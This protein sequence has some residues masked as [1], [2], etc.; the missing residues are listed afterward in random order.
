MNKYL[1]GSCLLVLS[2]SGCS[3]FSTKKD[4]VNTQSKEPMTTPQSDLKST[5]IKE[6]PAD[7]KKPTKGST[8]VV[9]YTGWLSDDK[10]QPGKKF[11]S[12][13]DRG[14]PFIFQVGVGQVIKGWDLG[15]MDMKVGEKRRFVIP[16]HLG[17]GVR[18][19]GAAIPP[20]ATLIFDVEL[21]AIQ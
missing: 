1:A 10:G 3:L 17:Y 20:N 9:H 16:P 13:V 2:L 7:A 14:Q 6:A 15:V 21:L 19:A 8:V 5:V 12:S 11:D 4:T 18:G